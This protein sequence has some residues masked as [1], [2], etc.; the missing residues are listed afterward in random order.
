M[1]E[2]EKH[3]WEDI[4]GLRDITHVCKKCK[5]VRRT[6]YGKWLEKNHYG[7]WVTYHSEKMYYGE[8]MPSC[9]DNI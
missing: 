1:M 4:S 8:K 2:N 5:L 3:E 9:V 7:T 6:E